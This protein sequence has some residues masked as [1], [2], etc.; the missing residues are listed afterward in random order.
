MKVVLLFLYGQESGPAPLRLSPPFFKI[1]CDVA[2]SLPDSL[3]DEAGLA[4]AAS[5]INRKYI[6]HLRVTIR[7]DVAD[8][9]IN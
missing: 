9:G 7:T 6:L 8:N 2:G 1:T 5:I 4:P 3:G